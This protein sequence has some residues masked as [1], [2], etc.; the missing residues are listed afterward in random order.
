MNTLEQNSAFDTLFTTAQQAL[1]VPYSI[2]TGHIE[3]VFAGMMAHR[4]AAREE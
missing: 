4:D 3:Q 1:L 2:E